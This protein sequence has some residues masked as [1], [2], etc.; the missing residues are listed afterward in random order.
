[1][2][3][4]KEKDYYL[5]SWAS[6]LARVLKDRKILPDLDPV[7]RMRQ[8]STQRWIQYQPH[9]FD[10]A[11][12]WLAKPAI[13]SNGSTLVVGCYV[14]RGLP[15]EV[16]REP[17]EIFDKA[18]HWNGLEACLENPGKVHDFMK[19]LPP[20]RACTR[21][22]IDNKGEA[23]PYTGPDSLLSLRNILQSIPKEKWINL[24][25]GVQFTKAECLALQEK[26]VPEMRNAI[27]RGAEMAELFKASVPG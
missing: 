20:A 12:F 26:I 25:L 10:G 8:N 21:L 1:M 6:S 2:S 15:R 5:G 19:M 7:W 23:T 18:W 22:W 27:T 16:T 13:M 3:I 4:F 9:G 14:E 24:L 17:T 11:A